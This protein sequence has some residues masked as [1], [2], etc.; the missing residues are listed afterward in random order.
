M[1]ISTNISIDI[2][3]PCVGTEVTKK[4]IGP[5]VR[6]VRCSDVGKYIEK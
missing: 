1:K 6:K 3:K 5:V 2:L 4:T